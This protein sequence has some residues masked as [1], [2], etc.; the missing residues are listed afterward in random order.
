VITQ[1]P[2]GR[3]VAIAA[4]FAL[5]CVGLIFFVWSTL[6]GSTPLKPRGYEMQITFTDASQLN[7][8]ADV[9]IAGVNVGKVV[10]VRQSGLN[11]KATIDLDREYAPLRSDARA[12][13]RQKT[14]LG[15]TF[16]ELSPGSRSAPVIPDG[17]TLASSQV[18]ERQSLDRLLGTLD[19]P[20]RRHLQQMLTGGVAAL[21]G[22][23]DDLNEALG[24]LDPA[25]ESLQQIAA[26]LDR[27]HGSLRSLVHD[28]GTVLATVADSRS[29]V[30]QLMRQG[31][32]VFSTTASRNR[33][34]T[35][36]VAELPGLIAQLNATMKRVDTTAGI[37]TPTL[38]ALRPVAGKAVPALRGLDAIAPQAADLFQELQRL[39]PVARRALPATA[40]LVNGLTPFTD[41][42]YPTAANI[43]PVIDLMSAYKRELVSSAANVAAATQA[44]AEVADGRQ[45]NYLRFVLPLTE[46][47]LVGA[48]QREPTNRHDAYPAPGSWTAIGREGL[49]ASDCRNTSNP[50][51]RPPAGSGAPPCRVQAP[52]EFAGAK[53]SYPHVDAKK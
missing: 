23:G 11:S 22:R 28:G 7:P 18:L 42:L 10:A 53:R 37:A 51:T 8:N 31:E 35:A 40:T 46:E 14:L 48:S 25:T 47:S 41:A 3:V 21:G 34:L 15:E 20:T 4:A 12:I 30:D 33:A 29:Q 13:L 24:N 50:Q 2:P 43:V 5:S 32:A 38:R 1:A 36:T 26:M 19:A 45:L 16:V 39:I 44:T 52:W 49:A 27:Q 9:R 6:G 17:G